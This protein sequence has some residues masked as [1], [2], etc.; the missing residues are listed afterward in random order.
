MG[1]THTRTMRELLLLSLI[2]VASGQ[3]W[4]AIRPGG[5]TTCSH[6]TEFAFFV[7]LGDPSKLVVELQG[8][9]CCFSALTCLLPQYKPDVDV[10]LNLAAL[11]LG[12]GIHDHNDSRN[13]VQN[14]T[15]VFVPYC[16]GDAHMGNRTAN[17]TSKFQHKGKVNAHS[18]LEWVFSRF[19]PTTTLTTGTSA[20][21]VGTY[22]LAPFIME[23]YPLAKHYHLAD[24]YAPIFGET[25]YNEGL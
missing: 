9:G 21:A 23:H 10:P 6:G 18:A 12:G 22:T 4:Q 16:T 8:G 24:S 1:D 15:H 3:N 20:G 11:N 25:G 14:W 5:A 2:I 17:Y 7:R 19:N 13:P